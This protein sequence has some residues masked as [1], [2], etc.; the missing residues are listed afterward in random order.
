MKGVWEFGMAGV[1][2]RS[3]GEGAIA[4]VSHDDISVREMIETRIRTPPGGRD[5]DHLGLFGIS[6]L[7]IL[8]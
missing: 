5:I 2:G 8:L 7:F 4:Q 1:L 6:G 3:G